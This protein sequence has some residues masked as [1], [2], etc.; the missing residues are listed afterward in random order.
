MEA[1]SVLPNRVQQGAKGV[2]LRFAAGRADGFASN[3]AKAPTL[4]FGA[5]VTLTSG[6]FQILNSTEAAAQ[7][8]VSETALGAVLVRISFYSPDGTTI[9]RQEQAHIGVVAS[10]PVGTSEVS[11]KADKVSLLAVNVPE[12]QKL[13]AVELVGRVNGVFTFSPPT[14]MTFESNTMPVVTVNGGASVS[15]L[16]VD[17]GRTSLSFTVVNTSNAEV[18][19]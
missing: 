12:D 19:V 1:F 15:N 4:A 18:T 13:G 16:R 9:V 6:S 14:G 3:S 10:T 8:D 5:G 2:S 7:V 17:S 11:V